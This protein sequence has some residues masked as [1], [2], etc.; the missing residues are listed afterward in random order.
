MVLC[1]EVTVLRLQVSRPKPE[2]ADRAILAAL[3]GCC[4]QCHAL[5]GSSHLARCWPGI[6]A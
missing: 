4:Q 5:I 2:W 3:A 1:H 6:A